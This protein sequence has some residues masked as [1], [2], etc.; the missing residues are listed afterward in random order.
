M[1]LD[2]QELLAEFEAAY[3]DDQKASLLQSQIKVIK[4]SIK[5]RLEDFAGDIEANKKFVNEAYTRF[6]KLK[7]GKLKATDEDYY[8]L[9]STVDEFFIEEEAADSDDDDSED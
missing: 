3:E 4:D 6:K 9:M 2:P 1:T 8:A 7:T 5:E